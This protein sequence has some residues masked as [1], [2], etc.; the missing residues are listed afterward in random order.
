MVIILSEV[1][2]LSSKTKEQKP[3]AFLFGKMITTGFI[4]GI[5]WSAFAVVIYLFNFSEVAPYT[6]LLQ[7]WLQASWIDKWQGHGLSIILSGILSLIPSTIYYIIF[8]RIN[9]MWIGVVYGFF[10]W[11]VLFFCI[12]PLFNVTMSVFELESKTI[13]ATIAVFVLYGTFIGYTISYNDYDL[14]IKEQT[15]K[16]KEKS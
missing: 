13:V 4:G 5:I 11:I 3:S 14:K 15:Q 1:K 9:S 7:P 12:Q 16:L 10:W 8:K 2:Q 6:Y